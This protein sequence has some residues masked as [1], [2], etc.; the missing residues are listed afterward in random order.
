MSRKSAPISF[1]KFR[2][3]AT[4]VWRNP[5]LLLMWLEWQAQKMIGRD[6]MFNTP[7]AKFGNFPH[8][9]AYV[10]ASYYRPTKAEHAL[11]R[12]V[13]RNS[14]TVIDIGA[15][16]G[17]M[18]C[19]FARLAPTSKVFAIE[20]HPQT[21]Q[22]LYRNVCTNN[23]SNAS[24]HR[25]AIGKSEGHVN[26]TSHSSP[27]SNRIAEADYSGATINVPQT[28]LSTFCENHGINQIDFLKIDVEGAELDVINGAEPL[29]RRRAI[30]MGLIEICPGTV[31]RVGVTIDDL[32]D[33]L[34][35]LGYQLCE[36]NED[37]T[38]GQ[39]VPRGLIDQKLLFNALFLPYVDEKS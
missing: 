18:T 12:R 33:R 29:L 9:N 30:A 31:A 5:R 17:V 4:A 27:A 19:L 1:S 24:C 10:G 3:R 34:H 26:F 2:Q 39:L 14:H 28:T 7:W 37:G 20:P 11:F 8:F 15:N 25:F 16:F 35:E 32:I 23:I 22:S 13:L 21:A 6:P 36:I 38:P